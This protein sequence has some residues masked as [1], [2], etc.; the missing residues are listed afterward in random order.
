ML[1]RTPN[2]RTYHSTAV[3]L[4]DGRTSIQGT[5]QAT[6]NEGAPSYEHRAEAFTPPWLLDGTPRPVIT[7]APAVINYNRYFKVTYQGQFTRISLMAPGS[8]THGVEFSQRL[9][10]L[11]V[12]SNVNGVLTLLAPTDPTIALQGYHMLF[13]VNNDTP[14]IARWVR[15]EDG[16]PVSNE[17][18][19]QGAGSVCPNDVCCSA[20]GKCGTTD[21]FCDAGCQPAFGYCAP[22]KPPAPPAPVPAPAP[23]A[24]APPAEDPAPAP[25]EPAPQG[26]TVTVPTGGS[27]GI[28]Q[29]PLPK[30][31]SSEIRTLAWSAI[32]SLLALLGFLA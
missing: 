28:V 6:Y 13:I 2:R 4:P 5:D 24:P 7:D 3:L 10:F 19:G 11:R 16:M 23:P 26:T 21:A 9:V 29:T 15:L 14:S 1:A 20:Q 25:Q 12:I 22:P 27:P 31:E 18:C 8:G 32:T 17:N 30:S